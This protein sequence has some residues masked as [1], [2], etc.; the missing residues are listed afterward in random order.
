VSVTTG[1]RRLPAGPLREWI[2]ARL[3]QLEARANG[4]TPIQMLA[5]E[6]GVTK[7]TLFRWR[8]QA[9]TPDLATVED[10]LNRA[11]VRLAEL[12][13][14][15]ELDVAGERF[16]PR[17]HDTV[18]V[19]DD[20]RCP[21]CETDTTEPPATAAKRFC[22]SCDRMV[23][24]TNAGT[25]WRCEVPVKPVPW[26][27]CACGCGTL[28]HRFGFN[29]RKVRWALGHAPRS[30][31][32]DQQQALAPFAEWLRSEL[33]NLDPIE[34]LAKRTGLSRSDVLYVLNERGDTFSRKQ[35]RRALWIAAGQGGGAGSQPDVRVPGFF[36]L[37]PDDARRKVC[38]ECG[39]PKAGHAAICQGCRIKRDKAEGRKPPRQP[40]RLSD[41]L[42]EEAYRLYVGPPE[43]GYVEV[44]DLIFDRSASRSVHSLANTL[45]YT[46]KRNGWRTRSRTRPRRFGGKVAA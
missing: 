25:C 17:C 26:V 32:R 19:A 8:E 37:Y 42:V 35:I 36:D 4:H 16:C 10:A 1:A 24:P 3:G 33:R 43:R 6:L 27:P 23:W 18:T 22:P 45:R 14:E 13:P 15:F 38:P 20:L 9:E 39:G 34:A 46:F 11:G 12:Y 5:S 30:V 31:E 41:A 28:I 29:G 7:R 2:D 40:V 21:W 44:A